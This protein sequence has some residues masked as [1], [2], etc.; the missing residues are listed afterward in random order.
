[1]K[2]PEFSSPLPYPSLE[3]LHPDEQDLR[4]MEENYCGLTSEMTAI[5]QYVYHQLNAKGEGSAKIASTLL[6][7]SMVEMRHLNLFGD[8]IVKL[9][10]DPQFSYP[11]AGK[12]VYWSGNQVDD[13]RLL[14]PMLLSDLKLEE[15]TIR[16]YTRQAETTLQSQLSALL[17]RIIADE[18]IHAETLRSLIDSLDNP[19]T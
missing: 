14:R 6:S 19:P 4:W 1:M 7:I 15:E 13:Y 18:V 12:Q 5:A 17:W 9:G 16:S 3:G 8:A 11:Q 10:G 2:Q